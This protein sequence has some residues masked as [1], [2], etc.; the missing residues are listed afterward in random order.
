[1]IVFLA[2]AVF[3]TALWFLVAGDEPVGVQL[4]ALLSLFACFVLV[5]VWATAKGARGPGELAQAMWENGVRSAALIAAWGAVITLVARSWLPLVAAALMI[6]IGGVSLLVARLARESVGLRKL[7]KRSTKTGAATARA[8]KR[9]ARI[10]LSSPQDF[11]QAA[12]RGFVTPALDHLEAMATAAPDKGPNGRETAESKR[13]RV[14]ALIHR[15]FIFDQLGRFDEGDV[16]ARRAYDLDKSL[17]YL[18]DRAGAR[19]VSM[20]ARAGDDASALAV[21]KRLEIDEGFVPRVE[22]QRL[23]APGEALSGEERLRILNDIY[24]RGGFPPVVL[25][26]PTKPVRIDNLMGVVTEAD[27][28]TEGPVVTVAVPCFNSEDSI[29][30]VLETLLEQTYRPLDVIVVDDCSTDGT[31]ERV[32]RWIEKDPRVRLFTNETNSGAYVSRNRALKEATGEYFMVRDADDWAHPWQIATLVEGMR[33]NGGRHGA[34]VDHIR[35]SG[36]IV[37]R[38]PATNSTASLMVTVEFA[39]MLG[40]WH[41]SRIGA[42]SEFIE[43]CRIECGRDF[44]VPQARWVPLVLAYVGEGNLTT[45]GP[46]AVRYVRHVVGVRALYH[47]AA[48]RYRRSAAFDGTPGAAL[49]VSE[50]RFVIPRL[51]DPALHGEAPHDEFDVILIADLSCNGDRADLADAELATLAASG[52]RVGVINQPRFPN[53]VLKDMRSSVWDVIDGERVRFV[54]IGE[55]VKTDL[56]W[57]NDIRIAAFMTDELPTITAARALVGVDSGVA[58]SPPIEA[59]PYADVAGGLARLTARF[60]VDFRI[61]PRGARARSLLKSGAHDPHV[62]EAL[63]SVDAPARLATGAYTR[64]HADADFV[65]IADAHGVFLVPAHPGWRRVLG[66]AIAWVPGVRAS[67][68]AVSWSTWVSKPAARATILNRSL[69]FEVHTT[70]KRSHLRARAIVDAAM[71]GVPVVADRVGDILLPGAYER[72]DSNARARSAVSKLVNDPERRQNLVSRADHVISERMAPSTL[73]RALELT[74]ASVSDSVSQP[75]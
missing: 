14:R 37:A 54:T 38:G 59:M 66:R 61:A 33:A 22:V 65:A 42:D 40:G 46:R 8:K 69:V 73:L 6:L 7:Y 19:V 35:A 39:R 48:D 63:S 29:D 57:V 51:M 31:R 25:R 16:Q 1:V 44:V 27:F 12:R 56:L 17:V 21:V 15:A 2:L 50:R 34:I 71:A 47:E 75:N 74:P 49:P 24:R 32:E 64:P 13:R 55:E 53:F 45:D 67:R 30:F 20:F 26:D 10:G 58:S 23:A 28:I 11:E 43:R 52:L 62:A 41:E 3:G 4:A 36:S 68:A 5:A 70:V 72:A 9:K 60:G 18:R